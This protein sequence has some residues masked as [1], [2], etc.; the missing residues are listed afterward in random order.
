MTDVQAGMQFLEKNTPYD[1]LTKYEQ[2]HRALVRMRQISRNQQAPA[3]AVSEFPH[4]PMVLENWQV[5]YINGPTG[6]GKTAWAR[7]LLPES[8]CRT[9]P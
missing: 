1:L 3:R 2:I 8:Y 4:A 6:L 7:S 5:L 9:S